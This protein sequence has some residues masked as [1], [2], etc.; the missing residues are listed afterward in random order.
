MKF[1]ATSAKVS[2]CLSGWSKALFAQM[3]EQDS[4]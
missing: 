4:A 3:G 2:E 1:C